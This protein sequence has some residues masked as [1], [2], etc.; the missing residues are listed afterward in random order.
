MQYKFPSRGVLLLLLAWSFAAPA[1]DESK[2]VLLSAEDA[3]ALKNV[4]VYISKEQ[5]MASEIW[6]PPAST[7]VPG[8]P[9]GILVNAFGTAI[10]NA[11]VRSMEGNNQTGFPPQGTWTPAQDFQDINKIMK[12]GAFVQSINQIVYKPFEEK[13]WFENVEISVQDDNLDQSDLNDLLEKREHPE[14]LPDAAAI[15]KN[16]FIFG[17][18]HYKL[19]FITDL[20]IYK[21]KAKP[22]NVKSRTKHK[23]LHQEKF[24]SL[25]DLR[26]HFEIPN[27]ESTEHKDIRAATEFA[28]N[29]W[30]KD[31]GK[32]YFETVKQLA[33]E[34][35]RIMKQYLIQQTPGDGSGAVLALY[36]KKPSE[37]KIIRRSKMSPQ[38]ERRVQ[39]K[40]DAEVMREMDPARRKAYMLRKQFEYI[41]PVYVMENTPQGTIGRDMDK[42][43]YYSVPSKNLKLIMKSELD[44]AEYDHLIAFP[45]EE[46]PAPQPVSSPQ[47][48]G[49]KA[50]DSDAEGT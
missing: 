13:T 26:D 31:N 29:L 3:S 4:V 45:E 16:Q 9:G 8:M 24:V 49:I 38:Q 39:R 50:T 14:N 34:N 22:K 27:P 18:D 36:E 37:K 15:L 41:R 2:P 32:L 21:P 46:P 12:D 19:W 43:V 42:A 44:P 40:E 5:T 10:G 47:E 20:E 11:I 7:G 6:V 23:L 30:T 25:Y 33:G 48:N 35:A 28:N 17:L 1:A